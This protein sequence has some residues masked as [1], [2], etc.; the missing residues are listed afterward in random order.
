MFSCW[1]PFHLLLLLLLGL[2]GP[3]GAQA[4]HGGGVGAAQT[5]GARP[6]WGRGQSRL[7]Q[8]LAL[9]SGSRPSGCGC[10]GPSGPAPGESLRRTWVRRP[11]I[12]G[13]PEG[14]FLGVGDSMGEVLSPPPLENRRREIRQ[15]MDR[16][17]ERQRE[18]GGERGTKMQREGQGWGRGETQKTLREG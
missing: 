1:F 5:A 7:L 4:G 10:A 12:L 2:G 13:G 15:E 3:G 17:T 11:A 18:S 9:H 16:R 14:K 8:P 6:G